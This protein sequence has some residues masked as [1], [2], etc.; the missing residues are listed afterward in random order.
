MD[1]D[2]HSL[3]LKNAGAEHLDGSWD[4]WVVLMPAPLLLGYVALDKSLNLSGI[5]FPSFSSEEHGHDQ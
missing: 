2:N 5:Q 4:Y 3:S 1:V